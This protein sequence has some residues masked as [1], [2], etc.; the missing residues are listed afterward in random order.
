MIL[1]KRLIL[2]GMILM[3]L[4]S[5]SRFNDMPRIFLIGDSTVADKPIVDNPECG[6]GQ[7]FPMLLDRTVEIHNH[8]RNGRSTKSFLSEGLWQSVL[9]SIRPGD[10]V[11]IQFGHND[12]KRE[13]STRFADART[14]YRENLIRY[15]RDARGAGA[16]PVLLTP[17]NRRSFDSGGR[18]KDK[19]G[20]YPAVVRAI[21][22]EEQV[23]LIDLHER[24]RVLFERLGPEQTTDLFLRVPPGVYGRVPE[25]KEDNTHFSKGG[26]LMIAREVAAG[27]RDLG[28]PLAS[29]LIP[30]SP[31]SLP[32]LGLVVGLD[33]YFNNEWKDGPDGRKR[34][35]HYTWDD[36]ANSGYSILGTIVYDLGY[37]ITTC[38]SA[39]TPDLLRH[40]SLYL[41]V[42]PDTP[43]ESENPATMN[44]AFADIIEHW[45]RQGGV[46]VL[47]ANDSGNC[48]LDRFNILSDRFGIHFNQDSHHRVRGVDYAAGA[49]DNLPDHP[50]FTGVGRTFTKEVSS[51]SL[52]P[53]A[54]PLLSEGE[55]VLM[56][57]AQIGNGLVFAV[58]DPWLY[59]E[60]IDNRRLPQG[61]NNAVA[62][63]NLFRWLATVVPDRE[64]V[65]GRFFPTE[66]H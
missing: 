64:S 29:H 19:H 37:T 39:P 60:Y 24:S 41:I 42:D 26:A 34:S 48:E 2:S 65:Q 59:N 57:S 21:A 5:G 28:L 14:T 63:R 66:D 22:E 58:G 54:K 44:A 27:V 13:D 32:G 52:S 45:V 10:Y 46:L 17:V 51:L 23:P 11:F 62:A 49:N 18:F 53:P 30:C 38:L 56:A 7:M 20:E 12:Q 43:A 1:R 35:F 8:A 4:V 50:L 61:F 33:R 47:L 40:V 25:G 6:W 15:V 9:D 31:D 3:I 16:F 36:T 55:L